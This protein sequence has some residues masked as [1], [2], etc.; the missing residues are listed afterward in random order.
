MAVLI[1]CQ[2]VLAQKDTLNRFDAKGR[3]TGYWKK[4][5]NGCVLYEGYFVRNRPSGLFKYYRSDGSLKSTADFRQSTEKVYAITYHPT[6]KIASQGLF[7]NQQKDSIWNYYNDKGGL[8][9]TETYRFGYKNG[10]KKMY[11][12]NTDVLI[13]EENYKNDTLDGLQNLWYENGYQFQTANYLKGVLN[14]NYQVYNEEGKP[15]V[16]G[17][18]FQGEKVGNWQYYDSKGDLRK[19]ENYTKYKTYP[20]VSLV[21]SIKGRPETFQLYDLAYFVQKGK[22]MIIYT[23]DGSVYQTDG[24]FGDVVNYINATAFCPVNDKV[25]ASYSSIKSYEKQDDGTIKVF[26]NPKPDFEVIA[27]GEK[28]Q[29]FLLFL[30]QEKPKQE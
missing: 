10:V 30:N 11:A 5:E 21:F 8:L 6:Q 19:I 26:L 23:T 13:C 17:C 9:E 16:K 12:D 18:Y 2:F 4:V 3:K 15:Y 27:E 20:E 24:D 22:K 1:A 7:I 25:L 28:A 14:G 29:L